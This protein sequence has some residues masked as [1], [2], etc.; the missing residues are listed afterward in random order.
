MPAPDGNVRSA[1]PH[2]GPGN[3]GPSSCTTSDGTGS[4]SVNLTSGVTGV[5]TV[6]AHTTVTVCRRVLTRN[7][8]GVAA[9]GPAVKTWVNARISITPNATN[10]VG[11]PHTFTVTLEKDT[12]TGTF[13][14][15]R[16]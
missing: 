16:R 1:S 12:G 10:E 13:V 14:A 2:S 4:C 3:P 9:T 8:D 6:S 5:T 15:G 7:T 11:Q